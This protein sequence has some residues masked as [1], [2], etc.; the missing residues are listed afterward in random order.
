MAVPKNLTNYVGVGVA[1]YRQ[2]RAY[3]GYTSNP[4]PTETAEC[5]KIYVGM[6][7]LVQPL[8]ALPC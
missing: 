6:G 2:G 8:C 7:L 4:I 5:R 1:V 3:K